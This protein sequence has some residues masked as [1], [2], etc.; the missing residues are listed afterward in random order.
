[1]N[2]PG[3]TLFNWVKRSETRGQRS[4]KDRGRRSEDGG[5]EK[6]EIGDQRSDMETKRIMSGKDLRVYQKAYGLD[7]ISVS[8]GLQRKSFH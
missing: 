4:G 1:M 8:G 5:Q 3:G 6:T 7:S 2:F